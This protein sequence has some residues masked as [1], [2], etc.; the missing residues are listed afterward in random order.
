MLTF[1]LL[2][3]AAGPAPLKV[4][5]PN[6]NVISV[7]P[8]SAAFFMDRFANRLRQKGLVV[9]TA[10]EIDTVL[11]LERQKSLLGCGDSGSCQAEIA[12]ALGADAIV[13]ARIARFGQRFELS[14]TLI[15]PADAGVL[16]SISAS[17]DDEGKVLETLD[18][19]A[20]ELSAKLLAAKHRSAAAPI[21]VTTSP[22]PGGRPRWL[23]IIP[24]GLGLVA[25]AV[26]AVELGHSFDLVR[27]IA[28]DP[29][30]ENVA[31]QARVARVLGIG[32]VSLGV[33]GLATAAILFFTGHE[34]VATPVAALSH[35]G[36]WVG[37]EGRLP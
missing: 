8:D 37:F 19:G 7:S 6:F 5:V 2:V 3:L 20:D 34:P 35:D 32:L 22:S 33:A 15:D 36:A 27:L 26:G 10:T 11:G 21:E 25:G 9:T 31:D 14:L 4:A 12:A 24:L 13:R 18:A 1:C 17:A 23:P 29:N 16:A 28:T 30:Y